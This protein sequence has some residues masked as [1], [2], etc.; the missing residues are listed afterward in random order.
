MRRTHVPLKVTKCT[1]LR[2]IQ[3]SFEVAL[4]ST[5]FRASEKLIFPALVTISPLCTVHSV[6]IQK[7]SFSNNRSLIWSLLL[8]QCQWDNLLKKTQVFWWIF[9]FTATI[10]EAWLLL[11]MILPSFDMWL[12]ISNLIFPI[13]CRSN[14]LFTTSGAECNMYH[15][16]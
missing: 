16:T 3:C 9:S 8:F 14:T 13:F 11:S 15:H 7:F 10:N 1:K 2:G 6:P 5:D 4:R 12:V